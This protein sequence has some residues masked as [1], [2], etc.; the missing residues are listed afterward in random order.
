MEEL[1]KK[2]R[3]LKFEAV[4]FFNERTDE[5]LVELQKKVNTELNKFSQI[6]R[7]ALQ[8]IPFKK[9]LTQKIK[10]FLYYR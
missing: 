9:T 7:V 8:P 6:H 2:Y 3:D 5:I 10:P 1:E 4:A